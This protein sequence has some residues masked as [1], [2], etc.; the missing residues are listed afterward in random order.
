MT[1]VVIAGGG[2][3]GSALAILLGR[4]GLEVELFERGGFPRE[5]PC[6]EGIMPAGVAVLERL[7]LAGAVGGVPLS[8]VRYHHRGTI[9]VGP[10]PSV[11][12]RPSTGLAQRRSVLDRVLFEAAAATPGV[13]ARAHA[14]VA[15]PIVEGGRVRGIVADGT[16]RRAALTVAADGVHSPLRR[17]LGLDVPARRRRVGM[18]A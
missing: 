10:F 16:E 13:T 18:R 12:G 1:D 2:V 7:G 15:A 17:A 4:A 9:A 5:K 11:N 3:A 6:G 14:T 8:G